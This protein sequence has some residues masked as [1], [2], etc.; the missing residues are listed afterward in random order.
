MILPS[1]LVK[2][3]AYAFAGCDLGDILLEEGLQTIEAFA[4]SGNKRVEQVVIP[5]SVRVIEEHAFLGFKKDTNFLLPED[6][7]YIGTRAFSGVVYTEYASGAFSAISLFVVYDAIYG[8]EN[9]IPYVRSVQRYQKGIV[10]GSGNFGNIPIPKR[11]GYTFLGWSLS[12]GGEI[13]IFPTLKEEYDY[14]YYVCF[15]LEDSL[16]IMPE[17]K[18]TYY[19]VWEKNEN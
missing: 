12:E 16:N 19:A 10:S 1:G 13:A 17:G 9:G 15:T 8:Y 7:E 11:A 5:R 18:S 6:V 14:S 4:F 2:V 3:G